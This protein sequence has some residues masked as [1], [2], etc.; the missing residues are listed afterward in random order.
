MNKIGKISDLEA[1]IA[2]FLTGAGTYGFV[3]YVDELLSRYKKPPSTTLKV[4]FPSIDETQEQKM[5]KQSFDF[6][7]Y[8][9]MIFGFPLGFLST[10]KLYELYKK[11]QLDAEIEEEMDQRVRLLERAMKTAASKDF[12]LTDMVCDQLV[13]IATPDDPGAVDSFF[14]DAWRGSTYVISKIPILGSWLKSKKS[15][16]AKLKENAQIQ[17]KL[18]EEANKA[19]LEHSGANAASKTWLTLFAISALLS[20]GLLYQSYQKRKS[21]EKTIAYPEK[22]ELEF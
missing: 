9:M 12:P 11:K 16:A 2:A 6:S 10:A 20:G 4:P 3:R 5:E 14:K 19:L 17:S 8:A 21:K 18:Q 1:F 13:K 7:N 22:V 15:F